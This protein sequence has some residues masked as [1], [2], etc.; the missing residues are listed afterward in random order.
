VS[1]FADEHT[2]LAEH[3]ARVRS[4]WPAGIPREAWYPHGE[5]PLTEYLRAWARLQPDK[6]AVIFYGREVTYAQLDQLSDQFAALLGAH[7]VRRAIASRCSFRTARNSMSR[8]SA[9]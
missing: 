9:S 4:A 8:S 2:Y 6:P 3:L 1:A 5:R 7:G